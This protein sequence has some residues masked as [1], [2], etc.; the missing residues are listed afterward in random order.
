MFLDGVTC[1]DASSIRGGALLRSRLDVSKVDDGSCL[2]GKE[3]EI[4]PCAAPPPPRRALTGDLYA[5]PHP[6]PE[7][8]VPY[9]FRPDI[10]PPPVINRRWPSYF[11]LFIQVAAGRLHKI[12]A[13]RLRMRAVRMVISGP[14]TTMMTTMVLHRIDF[15]P[16][17]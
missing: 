2:K 16:R 13:D 14:L 9:P 4:Q 12:S 10:G 5:T 15:Y 8:S 1:N 17:Q 7:A 6:A 11:L 3:N